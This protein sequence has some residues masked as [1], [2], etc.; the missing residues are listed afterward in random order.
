MIRSNDSL[1]THRLLI[2]SISR[3]FAVWL[4][5]ELA[6]YGVQTVISHVA[7][8]AEYGTVTS[9]GGGLWDYVPVAAS[10]VTRFGVAVILWLKADALATFV[11]R[12]HVTG[13]CAQCGYRVHQDDDAIDR[14]PECGLPLHEPDVK[15]D[16]DLPKDAAP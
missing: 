1:S 12:F 7:A 3:L 13:V 5:L 4:T 15:P 2:A 16:D 14:C 11:L 6:A 9:F 10:V 8:F